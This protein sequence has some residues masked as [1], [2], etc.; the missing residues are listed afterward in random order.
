MKTVNQTIKYFGEEQAY[1]IYED[2]VMVEDGYGWDI[3]FWF[4]YSVKTVE[5]ENWGDENAQ[6][7]KL[8]ISK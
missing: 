4:G 2:D 3:D 7:I 5:I 6:I 1:E 8:Y